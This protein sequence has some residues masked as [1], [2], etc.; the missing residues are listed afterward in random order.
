MVVTKCVLWVA[1]LHLPRSNPRC[2][3]QTSREYNVTVSNIDDSVTNVVSGPA[4][5]GTL[6]TEFRFLG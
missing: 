1:G 4:A 2:N 6:E 3:R 5:F